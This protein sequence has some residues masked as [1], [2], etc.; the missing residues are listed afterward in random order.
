MPLT[1]P[2]A[3]ESQCRHHR[4]GRA[5]GL[6]A[7]RQRGAHRHYRA[8]RD[9]D[10]ADDQHD[11]FAE[12]HGRVEGDLARDILEIGTR[13]EGAAVA[14]RKGGDQHRQQDQGA[15]LFEQSEEPFHRFPLSRG[16]ARHPPRRR[17]ETPCPWRSAAL[18]SAR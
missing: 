13:E 12:Y 7:N 3:A 14:D 10:A 18:R 9:V 16:A 4:H 2:T 15:A 6:E 11:R 5:I 8:D 1:T 17:A